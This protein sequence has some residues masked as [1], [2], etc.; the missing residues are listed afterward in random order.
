MEGFFKDGKLHGL[1]QPITFKMDK[2][3]CQEGLKMVYYMEK[4][5]ET[6]K[7]TGI[8]V[9][10]GHYKDEKD[11]EKVLNMN[12]MRILSI[13]ECIKMMNIMEKE[14]FSLQMKGMG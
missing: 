14:K 1:E 10:D 5:Q 9:F 12:M 4:S 3:L 6:H 2:S 7:D 8:I 11:M 13:K